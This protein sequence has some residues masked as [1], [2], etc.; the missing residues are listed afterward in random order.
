MALVGEY[1]PSTSEPVADQVALYER[2]DGVEGAT[3]GDAAC[4]ILTS[5]GA[6][7]GKLRKTPLM[8][9]TDGTNYLMVGSKGGAPEDPAWVHNL[10]ANPLAELR[11][12]AE[13][14][15][16]TVRELDG[17]EKSQWWDRALVAWP[18]YAEYQE[19]T[20]RLIPVFLLEPVV[21]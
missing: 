18:A 1:E 6:R 21:T 10:R 13:V 7:S 12:L 17:D 2:T 11:D 9:V 20:D 16:Y 3:M 19:N 5:V 15:E 14:H 4:I 8:K